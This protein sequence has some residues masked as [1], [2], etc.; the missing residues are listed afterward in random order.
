MT[1]KNEEQRFATAPIDVVERAEGD[2]DKMTI[3]GYAAV[4]DSLSLDL[5]GFRERIEPTAFDKVL[6]NDVRAAFNHN[7]DKILGRTS[8]GTLRIGTDT[9]GLWYEVDLPDTTHGRDLFQSVKRGDIKESSFKFTVLRDEWSENDEGVIRSISEVG[10]LVD[11][12]PV[13]FPAYPDATV[14]VRN[15]DQWKGKNT[16]T[17]VEYVRSLQ[18]ARIELECAFN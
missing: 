4:F 15:L 6:D 11:V 14:A 12:A 8:A 17:S 13:S 1:V 5:G 9:T 18:L 3:R 7:A 16:P 2:N 10:R